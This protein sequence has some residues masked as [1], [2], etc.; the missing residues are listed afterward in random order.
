MLLL[1]H[2]HN[3]A[4]VSM[5]WWARCNTMDFTPNQAEQLHSGD[6][7]KFLGLDPRF[8]FQALIFQ[9]LRLDLLRQ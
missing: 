3:L 7:L 9:T 5:S 1:L 8:Q 2:I 6:G 4:F